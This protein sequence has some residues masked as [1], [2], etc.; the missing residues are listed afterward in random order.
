MLLFLKVF[1]KNFVNISYENASVDKLEHY[2]AA[3][4]PFLNY[5]CI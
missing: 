2:M 3:V 1:W 5:N 4:Y